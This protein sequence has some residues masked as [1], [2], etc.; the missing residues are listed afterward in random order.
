M[1]TVKLAPISYKNPSETEC[2]KAKASA[3]PVKYK[4]L[5]E[6]ANAVRGMTVQRAEAY[7]KNVLAHKECVPFKIF[8][9]GIGKCAQAKQFR[10][11]I[12][13]WP[14]NAV[15][16][17]QDLLRNAISNAEF[18]GKD[19]QN[20]AIVQIQVNQ[21]PVSVRKTFRAHG[22]INPYERHLSHIQMVLRKKD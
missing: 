21:A 20:L 5:V 18:Y 8:K 14:K 11:I 9:G 12:G 22:R 15:K 1:K 17:V 16:C 10:T 3:I 6:T 19:T 13:R 2:V 4:N 7:L